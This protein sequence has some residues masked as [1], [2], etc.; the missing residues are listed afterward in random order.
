MLWVHYN[1]IPIFYLLKGDYTI[2]LFSSAPF[3]QVVKEKQQAQV[4]EAH[5]PDVQGFRLGLG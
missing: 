2:T 1:K 3:A 4:E 5:V